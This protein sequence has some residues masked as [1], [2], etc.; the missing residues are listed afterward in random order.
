MNLKYRNFPFIQFCVLAEDESRLDTFNVTKEDWEEVK[1]GYLDSNPPAETSVLVEAY[2]KAIKPNIER[3]KIVALITY[4]LQK[5]PEEWQ[6]YF[7]TAK[8]KYTGDTKKDSDYLNNKLQKLQNEE[9]I[10]TARLDK[11]K[12]DLDEAKSR[13]EIKEFNLNGVFKTIATLNKAGAGIQNFNTLTCGEYDALTTV[14][15]EKNGK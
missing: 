9:E 2:K 3:N 1:K 15:S 11:L 10:F 8:L 12:A 6:P 14:Y 4:I 7:E 13:E 5:E